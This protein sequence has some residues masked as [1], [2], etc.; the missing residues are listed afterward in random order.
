[1]NKV[2][3]DTSVWSIAL[4]RNKPKEKEAQITE[5]NDFQNYQKY[6]PIKLYKLTGETVV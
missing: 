6:L 4:R 5:D 1:M 3:I 2:L